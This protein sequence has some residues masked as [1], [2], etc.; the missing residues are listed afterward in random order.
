MVR[1]VAEQAGPAVHRRVRHLADVDLADELPVLEPE[2]V[3]PCGERAPEVRGATRNSAVDHQHAG[4]HGVG[5]DVLADVARERAAPAGT[6]VHRDVEE[7]AARHAHGGGDALRVAGVERE[8]REAAQ[9]AGLAPGAPVVGGAPQAPAELRLQRQHARPAAGD[10][11]DERR[12]LE[13]R[14]LGQ[15]REGEPA[16]G[17]D[18]EPAGRGVRVHGAVDGVDGQ[19]LEA[20]DLALEAPRR[21]A[22]VGAH[23]LGRRVGVDDVAARRQQHVG[24]AERHRRQP[25]AGWPPRDAVVVAREDARAARCR[26]RR[27]RRRQRGARSRA[28][29]R[30][31]RPTR[32]RRRR[33]SAARRRGCRRR[34]RRPR[35]RRAR[36]RGCR[37]APRRGSAS[38]Q[39][40]AAHVAP[41]SALRQSAVPVP[42][43]YRRPAADGSTSRPGAWSASV[44]GSHAGSWPL[45]VQVAPPS[46]DCMRR[47]PEPTA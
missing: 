2:R 27:S 18:D 13:R 46:S 32:S 12:A 31:G 43:L 36:V 41:P 3:R 11:E 42:R 29:P 10:V 20:H 26:R 45:V 1:H 6:A 4:R 23:E 30:P 9:R 47:E 35:S 38:G 15:R 28:G 16:V 44:L 24:G 25:G 21:A 7:V 40:A 8:V 37:T 14:A 39:T 34:A 5:L 17:A 33:S 19:R 22:V